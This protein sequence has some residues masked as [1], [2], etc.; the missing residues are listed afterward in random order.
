MGLI[1]IEDR[2]KPNLF[3]DQTIFYSNRSLVMKPHSVNPWQ[4]ESNSFVDKKEESK[5]FP[6]I[7]SQVE[8]HGILNEINKESNFKETYDYAKSLG[9]VTVDNY[10]EVSYDDGTIASLAQVKRKLS[11]NDSGVVFLVNLDNKGKSFKKSYL[12]EI[13]KKD[14]HA[15]LRMFDKSS[16]VDLDVSNSSIVS[17]W[18]DHSCTYYDC[19]SYGAIFFHDA[20]WNTPCNSIC[21]LCEGDFQNPYF[22]APCAVCLT[23]ISLSVAEPCDSN[24]CEY[25]PCQEDCNDMDGWGSWQYYCYQGDVWKRKQ[26]S[27]WA[28]SSNEPRNGQCQKV[29]WYWGQE[30]EFEP[31]N[32]GCTDYGNGNA[33]CNPEIKCYSNSDCPADEETCGKIIDIIPVLTP[34]HRHLIACI[35]ITNK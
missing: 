2:N 26:G 8:K 12:M 27:D 34:E 22:C 28:C 16:G 29:L 4:R 32:Y 24:S 6:K 9:Y 20:W 23:S 31:C 30:V 5:K 7:L 19:V 21:G 11:T 3:F 17:I 15:V 25:Y 10:T 14:G 1:S 13:G 35:L 33:E 18:G